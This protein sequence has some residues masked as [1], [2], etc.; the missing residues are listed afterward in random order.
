M[1]VQKVS[2]GA[3]LKHGSIKDSAGTIY[4]IDAVVEASASKEQVETEVKGDD[5]LK[6][7]FVSNVVEKLTIKANALTFDV[8]QAIT[9]N[10]LVSSANGIE[11]PL[12]TLNEMNPPYVEVL[13][14][15]AGKDS[16]GTVV[17]IRKVWHKV[18]IKS[19]KTNQ[20]SETEFSVEME[21]VAYQTAT[22]VAGAN[23]P[24]KRVATLS[25]VV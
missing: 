23:L 11:I 25:I 8:I 4:D 17:T 21:G 13:A 19:V 22:T 2:Y 1:A 15:V 18:Q 7:T 14:D 16:A 9:S 3:G 10:A 12:G 20:V 6:I 5:E 24:S